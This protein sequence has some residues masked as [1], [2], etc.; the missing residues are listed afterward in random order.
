VFETEAKKIA[1]DLEADIKK[2]TAKGKDLQ[3]PEKKL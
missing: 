2:E 1:S 3:K